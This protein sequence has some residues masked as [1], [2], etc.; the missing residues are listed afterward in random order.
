MPRRIGKVDSNQTQIV[1]ALR[2]L[3]AFVLL[4][5]TLGKGAPD[6]FVRWRGRWTPL[7]IKSIGGQLT[8]DEREW[9]DAA[10]YDE[11]LIAHDEYEAMKRL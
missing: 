10:G 8:D 3:G 9:W 7:E 1:K 6:I 5:H 4:T 2:E 11:P